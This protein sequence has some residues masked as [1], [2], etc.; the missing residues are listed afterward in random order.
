MWTFWREQIDP[1]K[2]TKQQS[3]GQVCR[4]TKGQMGRQTAGARGKGWELGEREREKK[5]IEK[6]RGDGETPVGW[7]PFWHKLLHCVCF[8]KNWS[9]NRLKSSPENLTS[10]V[11]RMDWSISIGW[12]THPNSPVCSSVIHSGPHYPPI[13]WPPRPPF[14]PSTFPPSLCHSSFV[15]SVLHRRSS[16]PRSTSGDTLKMNGH[17]SSRR[18]LS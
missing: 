11:K 10:S 6:G 5:E 7:I 17:G 14:S 13:S 16:E 9:V 3:D 18:S 4:K 2:L 1:G 8:L 15:L 12:R